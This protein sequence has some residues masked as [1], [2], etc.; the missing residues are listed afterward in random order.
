MKD[1]RP[2]N[3]LMET[4]RSLITANPTTDSEKRLENIA[5]NALG[6]QSLT[7]R[8]IGVPA[9]DDQPAEWKTTSKHHA[10]KVPRNEKNLR[11]CRRKEDIPAKLDA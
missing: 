2:K 11:F 10:R 9:A 6:R 5:V 3:I 7:R 8:T 4:N 1:Y